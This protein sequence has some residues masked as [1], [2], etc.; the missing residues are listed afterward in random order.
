MGKLRVAIVCESF[1][2]DPCGGIGVS[3]FN[4]FAGLKRKGYEVKVFT[5]EGGMPAK[6][7]DDIYRA[8]F[9]RILKVLLPRLVAG[10][11]KLQER[12]GLKYQFADTLLGALYGLKLKRSINEYGPDVLVV[13]DKGV[14]NLLLRTPKKCKTVFVSHHNPMRFIGEPLIGSHSVADAKLAIKLQQK[15]LAK[16]DGVICPSIYMKQTF[17]ETYSFTGLVEVIGNVV[18]VET[19]AAVQSLNLHHTYGIPAGSPI[20]YI[21]SAG[22]LIKGSGFVFEII[23]R[24]STGTS[25]AIGFYLSGCIGPELS[26]LLEFVPANVKLIIPG[27]LSYQENIA[28]IKGCSICVSPT[29]LESFGMA[30]LEAKVCGLT[31]IAFGVG[32]NNEIIADGITGFLVPFLDMEALILKAIELCNCDEIARRIG[33][34]AEERAKSAYNPAAVIDEYIKFFASL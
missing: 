9:P 23:R 16:V 3:C 31:C 21:P 15:A 12:G 25:G 14:S 20:V 10:W 1:P 28:F 26:R 34:A 19:I 32:G 6:E 5:I 4:L 18:D 30:L 13:P 29:I 33:V 27:R 17:L 11:I 24:L 2:P 7:V 8:G 22:S